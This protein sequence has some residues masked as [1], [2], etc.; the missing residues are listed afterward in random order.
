[1]A[2]ASSASPTCRRPT[3]T[4]ARVNG[5][6]ALGLIIGVHGKQYAPELR[7]R[8]DQ[9]A[10]FVTRLHALIAGRTLNPPA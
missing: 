6:A 7:I 9:M 3:P 5:A 10:T 2:A 4:S 1:M 8:R